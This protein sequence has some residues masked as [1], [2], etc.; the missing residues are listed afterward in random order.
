MANTTGI[1][2]CLSLSD[3]AGF[4]AIRTGPSSQE[5]FILW[6]GN[7]RAAGPIALWVPQLSMALARGFTVII[8]H[9]SSSAYIENVR[10]NAP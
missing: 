10:V 5:A 6:F 4:V 2:D 7:Q 1:I 3:G 9:G 8:S